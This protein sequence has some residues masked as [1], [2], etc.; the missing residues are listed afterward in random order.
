MALEH[1]FSDQEGLFGEKIRIKKFRE[2]APFNKCTVK[3]RVAVA[4]EVPRYRA[5]FCSGKGVQ[6]KK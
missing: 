4:V 3:A 5:Y 6:Y 1:L 2:T